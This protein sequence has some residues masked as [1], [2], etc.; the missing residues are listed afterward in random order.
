MRF[1]GIS[2]LG[3]LCVLMFLTGCAT[4][5]SPFSGRKP[6]AV[7]AAKPESMVPVEVDP[8]FRLLSIEEASSL[9]ARMAPDSGD[10]REI[11]PALNRSLDVVSKRSP[12]GKAGT[13]R[14]KSITWGHMAATLARLIEVL[15][16]LKND[17]GLLAREFDWYALEPG[18]LLTGYYEPWLQA[19]RVKTEAF[20]YPLYGKPDDLQIVDLGVFR[21]DLK[22]KRLTYRIENGKV[23]PYHTREDIDRG[24]ALDGHA[25]EIAW[26]ADPVDIFFLQIQGSG[27]LEFTDGTVKHVLYAGQNGH[28]YRSIGKLLIENGEVPKDEMSMKRIRQ[29]LRENPDK[30]ESVLFANP[31]Y[32]FFR[33]SDEGPFGSMGRTVQPMASVAV[34]RTTVPLASVLALF[35]ELPESDGGNRPFRTIV[36]AQDTGGAIKGSRVDLFCGSGKYAEFLAGHLQ[37][38]AKIYLILL[39]NM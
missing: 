15:P 13:V 28:Q 34:D 9:S 21:T 27:R 37:S 31:S 29:Y 20:P 30:M 2:R 11:E 32:V 26:V 3:L 25:A 38:D 24:G 17:P 22:N 6:A 8:F 1:L 18:T 16:F 4:F 36:S 33:L 12:A 14:E 7:P 39:K 10:W 35:T 19:S 23:V 5:N